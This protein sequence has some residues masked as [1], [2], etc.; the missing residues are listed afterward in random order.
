MMS[1]SF[2]KKLRQ[3]EDIVS[4]LESGDCG[5]DESIEL[6]TLGVKLTAECKEKLDMAKQKIEQ[7]SDY[8]GK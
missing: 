6:Y 1:E 5:L 3:I 2:E 7:L 8:D 4:K